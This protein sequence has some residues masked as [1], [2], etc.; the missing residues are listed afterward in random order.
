MTRWAQAM[1]GDHAL[2]FIRAHL[3]KLLRHGSRDYRGF[4]DQPPDGFQT[5]AIRFDGVR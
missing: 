4:M 2:A 5:P 1:S 3:L